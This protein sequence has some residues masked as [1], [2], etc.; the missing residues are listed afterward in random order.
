M[1]TTSNLKKENLNSH[2][3]G[4]SKANTPLHVLTA[5]SIIGDKVENKKG[6]TIGNIKDI[7]LDIHDGK[8]Q[9]FII[10]FGGFIGFGQKL[11]AVP[12]S[13]L[14]VNAKDKD[15]VLDIDK[16]FLEKAPGFDSEHWPN[17]NSHYSDVGIYW[18]YLI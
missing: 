9:Y 6:E 2:N 10:E 18:G 8:I 16:E 17:T 11:F 7:M 5:S 14:K 3:L 1:D 15:F 4:G 12:F 13:A